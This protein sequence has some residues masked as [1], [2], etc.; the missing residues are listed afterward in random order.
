MDLSFFTLGADT[1]LPTP[2][3]RSLWAKDQMH[4][5][6]IS[7]AL[8]RGM[9]GAMTRTDLRPARWSVDLFRPADMSPATV[10]TTILREGS[11][12]CLVESRF[13][14]DDQMRA[15]ATAVWLLPTEDPDGTVW[16]PSDLPT[17]PPTDLVPPMTGPNIPWFKSEVEWSQDF[18][19]HQ[20]S[21]RHQNWTY[22]V[23]VV[24]GEE[25]TPFQAVAS[26]ADATSMV[27]NWSDRGVQYIN[28]D[29][30]LSLAR[31]P[32]SAEVGLRAEHWTGHDGIAVGVC[33]VHDREGVLGH[34]M[35]TSL[36]NARRTV[37]F[38]QHDF[39][40]DGNRTSRV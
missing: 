9:E 26:I 18:K 39:D 7:G 25:P 12:L 38:D 34:S 1:L 36:T 19:D 30:S 3:A 40:G 5:V 33:T 13:V 27:C 14:Q 23:P 15:R 32:R 21:G 6:A 35:V 11:R 16:Q 24:S 4:G 22:P 20:N 8:A 31:L 2:V 10:E 29:I 28:T 37:D 17:P